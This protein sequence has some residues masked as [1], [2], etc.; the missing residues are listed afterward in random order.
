MYLYIFEDGAMLYGDKEVSEGD[1]Q[2][3]SEGY[4]TII[5]VSCNPPKKLIEDKWV[6]IEKY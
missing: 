4:L 1:K 3:C 2:S 6:E 5:D